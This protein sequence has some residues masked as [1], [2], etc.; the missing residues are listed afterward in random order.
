[1]PLLKPS[2]PPKKSGKPVGKNV[3]PKGRT[4]RGKSSQ[5]QPPPPALPALG[6]WDKLSPERKLDVVGIIL[7]FAGV[8]ILLGLISANRSLPVGSAIDFLSQLF[9]WGVYVLPLG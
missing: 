4:S 3:P 7:A 5:K 2:A 1:M 6:F 8:I 9:G